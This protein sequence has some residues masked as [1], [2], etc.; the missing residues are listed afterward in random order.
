M[1]KFHDVDF[2]YPRQSEEDF[3]Q[4]IYM[5]NDEI[6]MKMVCGD[7]HGGILYS[8]QW[9]GDFNPKWYKYV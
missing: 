8:M 4:P 5:R 1:V 9:E 7:P 3:T 2:P 6:Q